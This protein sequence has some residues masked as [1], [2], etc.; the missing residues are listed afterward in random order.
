MKYFY[1]VSLCVLLALLTASGA[2][3]VVSAAPPPPLPQPN[4]V[5]VK[6]YA[7]KLVEA[8]CEDGIWSIVAADSSR[9]LMMCVPSE[10]GKVE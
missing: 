1:V 5:F 10:T 3:E 7:G 9:V 8:K 6:V 4:R 2:A